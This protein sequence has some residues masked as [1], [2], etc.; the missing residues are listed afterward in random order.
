MDDNLQTA[1]GMGCCGGLLSRFK[2]PKVNKGSVN[3]SS[4]KKQKL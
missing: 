2:V 1:P 3:V 4:V